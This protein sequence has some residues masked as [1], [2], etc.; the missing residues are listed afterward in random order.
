MILWRDPKLTR[1]CP[2]FLTSIF[3]FDFLQPSPISV[4]NPFPKPLKL[5]PSFSRP[6]LAQERFQ[7]FFVCASLLLPL[8]FCKRSRSR[9]DPFFLAFA[10]T[11]NLSVLCFFDLS[12]GFCRLSGFPCLVPIALMFSASPTN[13][14]EGSSF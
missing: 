12:P 9:K 8:A 3:D 2:H 1:P 4:A 6:S 13:R 10:L 14:K 5:S 11:E 7:F